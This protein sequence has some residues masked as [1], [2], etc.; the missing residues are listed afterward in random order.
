[1]RTLYLSLW[2]LLLM[3]QSGFYFFALLYRSPFFWIAIPAVTIL[4]Y[5]IA[6]RSATS[7]HAATIATAICVGLLISWD[8]L[9]FALT[10]SSSHSGAAPLFF[11]IV[12]FCISIAFCFG[13]VALFGRAFFNSGGSR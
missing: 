11:A 1:M 5:V 12:Y 4:F 13:G 9:A 10:A 2:V 6:I 7:A 8:L 3:L